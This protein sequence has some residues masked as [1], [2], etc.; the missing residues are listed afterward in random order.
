MQARAAGVAD[1]LKA[2]LG[3]DFAGVWYDNSTGQFVVPIVAGADRDAS[4]QA[5][6]ASTTSARTGTGPLP[7]QSTMA[8]LEAAQVKVAEA[9]KD[10]LA[11]GRA[12]LGID[13][14]ITPSSSKSPPTPVPSSVPI[15]GRRRRRCR[16]T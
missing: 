4:R 14:N 1:A 11:E 5:V 10:L 9:I 12:R 7:V 2:R 15:F 6:P 13:A 3:S 8:E 16:R